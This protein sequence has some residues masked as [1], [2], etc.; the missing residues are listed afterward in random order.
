MGL[1]LVGMF[2]QNAPSKRRSIVLIAAAI[3]MVVSIGINLS[4]LGEP[5]ASTG[6]RRL[7]ALLS[8]RQD[9]EQDLRK[10]DPYWVLRHDAPLVAE[11]L[12]GVSADGKILIDASAAPL[13][14]WMA[15]PEQLVAVDEIDFDS[16]FEFPGNTAD[17]VLILEESDPLNEHYG[18]HD[19]PALAEANVNYASLAWS[20]DQTLLDWRLFALDIE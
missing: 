14:A 1:I 11:T 19:F 3:L 5:S 18:M 12:D 17:Y 6:E 9:L 13:T 2:Y 7:Q 16:L 10:M 4:T 20:S 15:H 8:G